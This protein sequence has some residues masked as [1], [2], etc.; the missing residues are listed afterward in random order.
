MSMRAQCIVAIISLLALPAC[1]PARSSV[2]AKRPPREE[3]VQPRST[4]LGGKQAPERAPEKEPAEGEKR[5]MLARVFSSGASTPGYAWDGQ[6]SSG[7]VKLSLSN[8]QGRAIDTLRGLGFVINT[9][10]T[11]RQEKIATVSAG[12]ADHTTALVMLEEKAAGS[13]E[14]KVRVGLTGDR[15]SSERILDEM[16]KTQVAKPAAKKPATPAAAPKKDAPKSEA[17]K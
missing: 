13:T 12:K 17:A 7:T 15:G 2:E 5:G 3:S 16:Q 4:A 6:H 9:D 10:Q 8:A 1:G 14:V 11:K